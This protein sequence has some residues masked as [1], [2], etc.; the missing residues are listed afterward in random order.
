MKL[1]TKTGWVYLNVTDS[2]GDSHLISPKHDPYLYRSQATMFS[3]PHPLILYVGR[4]KQI[5]EEGGIPLQSVTAVDC[6][7]LNNR[8]PHHLYKRDANLL[9]FVGKYEWWTVSGSRQA[10]DDPKKWLWKDEEGPACKINE[11]DKQK[12]R[13]ETPRFLKAK[14][15]A[16]GIWKASYSQASR[17]IPGHRW[18]FGDGNRDRRVLIHEDKTTGKVQYA[19]TWDNGL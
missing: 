16:A 2:H 5:F 19:Y 7:G 13:D 8:A 12:I 9:N 1:R 6:W 14:Y 18:V 4:L 11:V 17:L 15:A 10:P 3:K